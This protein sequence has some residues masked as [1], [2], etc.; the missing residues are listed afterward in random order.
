M[1]TVD[2]AAG[3]LVIVYLQP[4]RQEGLWRPVAGGS[5]FIRIDEAGD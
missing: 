4:S 5:S 1:L 2:A 3:D